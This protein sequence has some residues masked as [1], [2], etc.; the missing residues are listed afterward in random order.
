MNWVLLKNSLCVSTLATLGALA[1]G[2]LAALCLVTAPTRWRR[3]GL[4]ATV[5]MLAMPSFLITGC[6]LRLLGQTGAWKTWLPL[7][8]YSLGG[9][10][11]LLALTLWPLAALLIL[12]AWQKLEPGW[13]ESDSALR[14]WAVLRWLLLPLAGSALAQAGV[15]VFVL[16]LNNFA[17]P[18]LLQVKVYPAEL[19]VGFNTTFN[20]AEALQL[21]W[22]LIAAPLL[23]L[24]ILRR[25]PSAWPQW[26][27]QAHARILRQHM[28]ASWNVVCNTGFLSLI[29]LGLLLPLFELVTD[30]A[31]WNDFFPAFSAG[32][33]ALANSALFAAGSATLCLAGALLFWRWVPAWLA[34]VPFL[35]PG[36]V[37][38]VAMIYLLN[39]HPFEVFYQ[40]AGIVLLAWFIRYLAPGLAG[41]SAARLSVDPRLIDMARLEGANGWALFRQVRW[42]QMAA[43]VA[44]VW[45]IL[46][47]LCLWD[48]ETLL[49][50]VPP[51]GETLSLRIF[52]LLH[53]GH[54]SQVNALCLWLLGLAILPLAL[55]QLG[56]C[57][58]PRAI[59][60]C[61]A[62]GLTGGCGPQESLTEAPLQSQLFAR[63]TVIG[64]RGTGLGQFN[65]PRA[66]AVDHD[67]NLY[68][69]DM[70][71]RVQKFDSHGV[72]LG[73]WQILETDKGK[74]KGMDL[75]AEGN[76]VVVE[77]HY[78][79][80]NHVSPE[81]KLVQRWGVNGTNGGQLA[82]PR[83]VSVN[84]RGE[85]IISEYSLVERVQRF[86]AQGRQW[87][88]AFGKLGTGP[89]EFNR[90][91]GVGTDSQD[92][93]YVADSCNHRIQIFTREGRFIQTYGKAGEGLG[94]LS[95][96]Y[97]IKVD[98]AGRQ[99]VSEFGN[100]RIQIFDAQ[101]K[102]LETIGRQG[103][104]PGEFFNPWSIALDSA[105]NLY[106]ADANNHRVQK[107]IR[108]IAEDNR[109]IFNTNLLSQAAPTAPASPVKPPKKSGTAQ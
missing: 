72:F 28:G 35:T 88:G 33:T 79:R 97:D 61:L 9:T 101:N 23:L 51:G 52:N 22:P 1:F 75:D 83:S 2:L 107:L 31:T 73:S 27:G 6:W 13:L 78:T 100:S 106:V 26:Q 91:E 103:G 45:Y 66:L 16:A 99:Y 71:A 15:L 94:E 43:S 77:P 25:K 96:P 84:T 58:R 89:G 11:W 50:V 17:I 49:L 57:L 54:N 29:S 5:A 19:W 40:S 62:A 93:I 30:P 48:V 81:L 67:D 38:G 55:W 76:I 109:R 56:R 14:G 37:L 69:V 32:R 36:V 98:R 18:A 87:L 34:W 64:S 95:Y 24:A 42:P 41:A 104:K 60:L 70:T 21:S 92:R 74:P 53:Y 8:I 85:L 20:Y 59:G 4:A 39:H 108:R 68:V 46:Y 105:G 102:P 3:A 12:A 10:V 90:P 44:A 65:K 47:L 63:A 82:F 80:V 7:N 86:A